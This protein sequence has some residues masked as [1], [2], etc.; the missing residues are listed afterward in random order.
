MSRNRSS[1]SGGYVRKTISLPKRLHDD[2]EAYLRQHEGATLSAT[3]STA[4]E[5]FLHSSKPTK[6]AR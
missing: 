2:L 4:A 6:K 3:M 1:I 5:A